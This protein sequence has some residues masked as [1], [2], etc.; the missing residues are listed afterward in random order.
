MKHVLALIVVAITGTGLEAA[1]F[2]AAD[3]RA[4][5]DRYCV[6][7]H[8]DRAKVG[9][10]SLA[11]V[12][13]IDVSSS[14]EIL[15][16]V[17]LKLRAKS[18]PP[19]GS[20]RPDP[21]AYGQL[22]SWLQAELDRSAAAHP[23]A[24][25]T[26]ALHRLN[27]AEYRNAIRDLL[28]IEGLNVEA[29]LPTDDASYGFDN[30]AGAL[31]MSPTHV[32]RY[33]VAAR[34][35]SH[36]AVGDL[37]LV[38]DGENRILPLDLSQDHR[39]E[40]LG[41]GTRG[42]ITL[43][44]YFPV[45]AEY[46]LQF[47]TVAGFGNTVYEGNFIEV[48]LDGERVY[49][50]KVDQVEAF[51]T[52]D[53]DASTKYEVRL[54][55]KAGPHSMTVTFL[56]TTRASVEDL[57]HPYQRPPTFSSTKHA[58]LGGY[59]G[60]Y[61]SQ[62]S[63]IGPLNPVGAADSPSRR[64]IFICVPS[65]PAEQAPCARRIISALARRAFRRPVT[66]DDTDVLFAS[67]MRGRAAGGF[68]AGIR[69]AVEHV[70]SSP[71]FLFRIVREPAGA[72]SNAPYA[73]DDLALASRL[74]FFLWSSIPDEEL[75]ALA[76]AGR[77]RAPAVFDRQVQ[78]MLRDRRAQAL[79]DN[80]AGQWLRLRNVSGVVPNT[81]MFQDFDENLR[82]AFR[83]ETE[84]FFGSIVQE[85]RSVLDLIGADYTFVNERLA[86]HYGIPG[87]YG[88]EFQRVTVT[89]GQRGG[90]LGQGSVL[91]ATSHSNRTSPVV[92]GKWI[93][94]NLLASPP[95]PPPANIPPLENTP[96]KGT[97]RQRMEQHRANPVCAS[98]HK[99]MDP[100]GFALENFDA[101]GAWRTH[102]NALP[103]DARGSLPDGTAFDGV[104]GL[105]RALLSQPDAFLHALTGQ[106]MTYA[107][108]RGLE[109]YD[110]PAVREVVRNSAK[111][112]YRFS[113]IV[114]GVVNSTPFRM[115]Q[116]Q[117]RSR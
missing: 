8:N 59:A 93:L 117:G 63:Y 3:A 22:Y 112:Q 56:E 48:A 12:D 35:I 71:D 23:N 32:E 104:A 38:P 60:P 9:G 89:N 53:D 66:A 62:F 72:A 77:L 102:E 20:P 27:R 73:I 17:V 57:L 26:E 98:C 91:V 28:G 76:A 105:K 86:R 99:P 90:L 92:R 58:R 65:A 106:L 96:S 16:K 41:F 42:G 103:V 10:L 68:E 13:L 55:I 79:V 75:L 18:M 83:R 1:P 101:V 52:N 6:A 11:G 47:Q 95:P 74:S 2:S 7:C 97:L 5:V 37:S 30:I 31:A 115:R 80:F 33:Q 61:V 111:Q 108:G 67:Y 29:M 46:V 87:V 78:R 34:K 82:V 15:E 100:L 40:S 25:R 21:E 14:A 88:T 39:L 43:R 85:D 107:L 70:L 45:D 94:E 81:L 54:P 44:R 24:G 19:A 36:I 51:G 114:L 84:L 109:W 69:V 64:R 50:S 49:Y 4:T 110:A 116:A 113:S